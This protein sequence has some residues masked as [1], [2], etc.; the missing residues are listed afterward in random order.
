MSGTLLKSLW[1]LVIAMTL[2]VPAPCLALAKNLFFILDASGSMIAPSGGQLR[3]DAAKSALIRLVE[4]LPEP[5]Q[6]C[7][8]CYG[9]RRKGD[10]QD[11]DIRVP[12]GV[13]EKPAFISQVKTIRAAGMSPIGLSFEKLTPLLEK[14]EGARVVVLLTDGGETCGGAPCQKVKA[15]SGRFSDLV[16]HV[17]GFGVSDKA[18]SQLR[19]IAEAG[20]GRYFPARELR[21][22]ELAIHQAGSGSLAVA[23]QEA[24]ELISEADRP[25]EAD[26]KAPS[27][28]DPEVPSKV[29]SKTPPASA[30]KEPLASDSKAPTDKEPL[31]S[32]SKALADKE[33]LASD[34]KALADTEP[35]ASDSKAPTDTAPAQGSPEPDLVRRS[36]EPEDSPGHSPAD[37]PP[38]ERESEAETGQVPAGD[39]ERLEYLKTQQILAVKTNGA[40]VRK[41]PS[42]DAPILDQRYQ[43]DPVVFLESQ[44]E[45]FRIRLPDGTEGWAHQS[46]FAAPPQTKTDQPKRLEAIRIASGQRI[47]TVV[48]RLSSPAP[49]RSFLLVTDSRPRLVCDFPGFVLGQGVD[50]ER[51]LDKGFIRDIRIG[52]H[53]EPGPKLRVV[54]DLVPGHAYA[55]SQRFLLDKNQ[56][57]ISISPR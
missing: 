17:V 37:S 36:N 21:E 38:E 14:A 47:Q 50:T 9:H 34:S 48:F 5:S 51:A 43:G 4:G 52:R 41:A 7:L 56:H 16:V 30:P 13:L 35:L 49:P 27:E 10:C 22:L 55:A 32:D 11:A 26:P 33:P 45:W 23:R 57:E 24:P 31:A 25:L 12:P 44:G 15:L 3:L 29:A 46:L 6:V 8:I 2:L 53:T 39:Q 1:V 54:L 18:Q 19:C 28:A 20:G 40:R 42:L